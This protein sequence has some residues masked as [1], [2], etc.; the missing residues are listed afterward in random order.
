MLFFDYRLFPEDIHPLFQIIQ[1][2]KRLKKEL[3]NNPSR[4]TSQCIIKM[5][6][7]IS[8]MLKDN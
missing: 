8:T 1:I 3:N 4:G 6:L 2:E 5:Y 7:S